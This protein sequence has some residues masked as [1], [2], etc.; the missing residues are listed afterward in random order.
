M[1]IKTLLTIGV[2]SS[3]LILTGCATN[4]KAAQQSYT[5]GK[6]SYAQQNYNSSFQEIQKAAQAGDPDAEYALGYM[7]YYGKGTPQNTPQATAW[8]NKAAAQGQPQAI[9]ALELIQKS[10][11]PKAASA[12]MKTSQKNPTVSKPTEKFALS[13]SQTNPAAATAGVSSHK[14][15]AASHADLL[16]LAGNKTATNLAQQTAIA[17]KKAS[18]LVNQHGGYTLQL[19]GSYNKADV[20]KF[21][22]AN[23]LENQTAFYQTKFHGKD[24]YVLVYGHYQTASEAKAAIAQLPADLQKQKPWVKPMSSVQTAIAQTEQTAKLNS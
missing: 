4:K 8:M 1:N 11:N 5:Q 2:C 9:K 6:A 21:M 14:T 19:L 12:M 24:W 22:N 10:G 13:A 15:A 18:K 17:H 16:N 20:V 7:L 23:G 3:A